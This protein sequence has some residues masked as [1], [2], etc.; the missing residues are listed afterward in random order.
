M[1]NP[2]AAEFTDESG[3]ERL[4]GTID[5]TDGGNQP[6]GSSQSGNGSPL[7]V[8]VPAHV[9]AQY[10]DTTN[11]A[12]YVATGATNAD[13]V[14]AAGQGQ[15]S[16][17]GVKSYPGHALL[18][19]GAG[20][21]VN[22]VG[23]NVAVALGNT[24]NTFTVDTFVGDAIEATDDGTNAKLGFFGQAPAVQPALT[25]LSTAADIVAALQALGLSG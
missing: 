21:N 4:K 22:V 16:D 25:A 8:V 6:G 3:V 10:T 7:G 11:G 15:F 17:P 24:G 20:S 13:W 9:G 18:Q 1:A 12:L 23:A 2:Y 5:F 14:L 19:A